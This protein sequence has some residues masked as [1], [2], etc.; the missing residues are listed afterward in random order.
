MTTTGWKL[1][2][3]WK[4]KSDSWIHLK[5][6]KVLHPIKVAEYARDQGIADEPAFVWWVPSTLRKYDTILSVVKAKIRKTTHKY[7]IEIPTSLSHA[8]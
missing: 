1:Q 5:Y 8:Y 7:G 3:Q 4:D 2:V 6:I